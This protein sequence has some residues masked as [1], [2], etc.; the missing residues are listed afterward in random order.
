MTL[1]TYMQQ[2]DMARE[3]GIAPRTLADWE[4]KGIVPKG[5]RRGGVKLYKTAA[6]L[7]AIENGPESH[8]ECVDPISARIQNAANSP[9]EIRSADQ[10]P[11]R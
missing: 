8:V 10:D 7:N 6:V 2:K 5:K 11:A 4:K 1:P 9:A 3:C